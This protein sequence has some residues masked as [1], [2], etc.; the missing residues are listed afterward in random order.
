MIKPEV[1]EN[2]LH[3]QVKE[4]AHILCFPLQTESKSR[5]RR[6]RWPRSGIAGSNP[7][8]GMFVGLL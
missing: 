6:S 3:V 2:V 4:I 8:G 7:A 1:P 5:M